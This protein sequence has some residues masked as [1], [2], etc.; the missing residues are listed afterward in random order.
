MFLLNYLKEPNF[1]LVSLKF[2]ILIIF[3]YYKCEIGTVI[4]ASIGLISLFGNIILLGIIRS[5]KKDL[6]KVGTHSYM[7]QQLK[8]DLSVRFKIV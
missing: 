6:T 5:K 2:L 1:Q 7:A 4:L 8:P 3:I